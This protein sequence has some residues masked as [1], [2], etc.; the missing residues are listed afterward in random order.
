MKIS[1]TICRIFGKDISTDDIV[2]GFVLSES[3]ERKFFGQYCFFNIDKNFVKDCKKNK[4]NIIVASENFGCGSSREQA[5]YALKENNVVAVLAKSFADIFYRNCLVNNLVAIK[6]KDPSI[7]K[8]GK[9]VEIDLKKKLIFYSGK[10]IPFEISE[11]D[12]CIFLEGGLIGKVKKDIK[13][14]R[15]SKP[16]NY[17]KSKIK[18][19]FAQTIVEKIVSDHCKKIL[20]GGERI[21]RLPVDILFLNEVIGPGT[22]KEFYENFGKIKVFSKKNIFLVLDHNVPAPTVAVAEGIKMMKNFAKD[23]KL[24]IYKEGD[25]IEHIVLAEDGY[26][27][28]GEIVVGTDSH[29]CTNGAFNCLA[30]GIGTTEASFCLAT[31]FVYDFTLPKT[32]R[33]EIFGKF[34]KGVFSKDLSLFLARKFSDGSAL[35]KILEFGGPGLKNLSL[36]ARA[37]IS[38][39]SV[40][41][42]A[43]SAIFEPDEILENYLKKIKKFPFK[44]YFPDKNANYFSKIEIDLG[45][46]EPQVAFPPKPSN[47]YPISKIKK[48]IK[49]TDAFLGSCTNAR[50]EDFLVA[51]K[52]IKNRKVHP[53]VNFIVIPGSRKIYN[54]LLREGILKYFAEAGANIE[55]PNCGLCFGKHMGVL[56]SKARI[57]SSSNRNFKG[58]MGSPEAEIYLASP[59]TV[60]ASAIAG[61]VVNPKKFL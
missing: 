47:S 34:K 13:E 49:I 50:Y 45:E 31:G 39:M 15:F 61:K 19:N 52:I 27:L 55:S 4:F 41:M 51:S 30:F 40:E 20:K 43:K 33:I 1:G 48:T 29:T 44:F 35:G 53:D 22:I 28:P 18:A 17:L 37:T 9:K 12:L 24:K 6:I 60:V 54:K 32:I 14:K 38:N 3:V 2:P 59:A 7:F 21:E 10:K 36:D 8:V 46:I 42:G 26:I 16:Q 5:V 11:D 23:Q 57:I 56:A 25:G 58:R